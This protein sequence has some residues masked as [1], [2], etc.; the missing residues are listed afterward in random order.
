MTVRLCQMPTP[1]CGPAPR[2]AVLKQFLLSGGRVHLEVS[3]Q[4][5]VF[6]QEQSIAFRVF[7][8][9]GC[10]RTVRKIK[11]STAWL[12]SSQHAPSRQTQSVCVFQWSACFNLA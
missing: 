1:S 6:A 11:V 3:L 7:I 10:K 5:E 4:R 9:N 8:N 2:N 12:P